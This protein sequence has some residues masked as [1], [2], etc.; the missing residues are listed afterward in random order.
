[1]PVIPARWKVKVGGPWW[2]AGPWQKHEI[3]AQKTSKE[4]RLE[5]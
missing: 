5:E 4:K 2:E 1:M 3:L